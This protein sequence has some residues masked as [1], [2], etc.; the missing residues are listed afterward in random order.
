MLPLSLPVCPAWVEG[1]PL[2]SL[3]LRLLQGQ[4]GLIPATAAAAVAAVAAV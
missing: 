4:G 2:L 1:I 3:L